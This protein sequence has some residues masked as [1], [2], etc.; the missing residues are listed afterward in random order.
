MSTLT[1]REELQGLPG[2]SRCPY[3]QCGLEFDDYGKLYAH[4]WHH[5]GVTLPV[6]MDIVYHSCSWPDCSDTG[7][8]GEQLTLYHMMCHVRDQRFVCPH[9]V[10]WEPE[11]RALCKQVFTNQ[12]SLDDHRKTIHGYIYELGNQAAHPWIDDQS[13]PLSEAILVGLP[14]NAIEIIDGVQDENVDEESETESD[15]EIEDDNDD[16]GNEQQDGAPNVPLIH[17]PQPTRAIV[18]QQNMDDL[19]Q[20]PILAGDHQVMDYNYR[21]FENWMDVAPYLG[22]EPYAHPQAFDV[23]AGHF[24]NP[25]DV[26]PFYDYPHDEVPPV[27]GDNVAAPHPVVQD[28]GFA[29]AGELAAGGVGDVDGVGFLQ[30]APQIDNLPIDVIG[31]QNML[32]YVDQA[33][34]NAAGE[35]LPQPFDIPL[36]NPG[37]IEDNFFDDQQLG[38]LAVAPYPLDLENIQE[39]APTGPNV[40]MIQ[41]NGNIFVPSSNPAP[42][43]TAV[44]M[45][46][47][48]QPNM[49][50]Q[51]LRVGQA[52][53]VL[54][55]LEGVNDPSQGLPF[56]LDPNTGNYAR[57][58]DRPGVTAQIVGANF[59]NDNVGFQV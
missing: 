41:R 31:N 38:P 26:I 46:A 20:D 28:F 22:G 12:R 52:V 55:R 10:N 18:P 7:I 43:S 27:L 6:M 14:V 56:E 15:S 33:V 30:Q 21:Q 23:G 5:K 50:L 49:G 39:P 45:L 35:I 34:D 44:A 53:Y 24:D 4:L 59:A 36:I 16:D 19:G 3:E 37:P 40:P 29:Y 13:V 17:A 42:C 54:L 57:R 32:A 48:G 9:L 51:T 2:I 47:L 8:E 11:H 1:V 58:Q 25:Q